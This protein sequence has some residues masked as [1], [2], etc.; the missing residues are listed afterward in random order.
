M[1][2]KDF[3]ETMYGDYDLFVQINYK[4]GMLKPNE[5]IGLGYGNYRIIKWNILDNKALQLS[6]IE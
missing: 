6:I 2:V 1:L 3:I 5:L 4:F